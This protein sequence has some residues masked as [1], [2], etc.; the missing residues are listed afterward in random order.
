MVGCANP[1]VSR[2]DRTGKARHFLRTREVTLRISRDEAL[3]SG[4][5]LS[6]NTIALLDA[7]RQTERSPSPGSP[8]LALLPEFQLRRIMSSEHICR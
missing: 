5:S 8:Q 4:F 6:R 7:A 1:V 3:L 2:K